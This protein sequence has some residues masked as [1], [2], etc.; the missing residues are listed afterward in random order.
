M[1]S[2]R[3]APFPLMKLWAISGSVVVDVKPY[4]MRY[5]YLSEL[6]FIL[7]ALSMQMFDSPR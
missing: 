3:R 1:M 5:Y 7:N 4:R 2:L 6:Y